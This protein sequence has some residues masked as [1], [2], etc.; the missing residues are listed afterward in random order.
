MSAE[1]QKIVEEIQTIDKHAFEMALLVLKNPVLRHSL[2]SQATAMSERL[3]VIADALK[4]MDPKIYQEKVDPISESLLDLIFVA[5][6]LDIVSLRL[7]EMIEGEKSRDLEKENQQETSF[8]LPDGIK[9]FTRTL[10]SDLVSFQTNMSLEEIG[11]FY[12]DAFGKQG[13]TEHG[14]VTSMSEEHLSLAFLGLPDDRMALVQ[15]IDLGYKTE[16]D[17]RYVSLRTEKAPPTISDDSPSFEEGKRIRLV[18][19]RKETFTYIY[20]EVVGT[21]DL[22]MAGTRAGKL[23]A[24]I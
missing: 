15:A 16:Q 24:N 19:E 20:V 9:N 2:A 1:L 14:L 8:P 3:K 18:E 10:K 11:N 23:H 7:G 22:L 6:D 13:L 21:G 12:R 5:K 17:L 4:N